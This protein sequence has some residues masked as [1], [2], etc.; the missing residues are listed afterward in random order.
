MNDK[1][2]MVT[3]KIN[4]LEKRKILKDRSYKLTIPSDWVMYLNIKKGQEI[5]LELTE[6]GFIVHT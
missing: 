2:I 1:S 5:A 4:P 3:K 6:N